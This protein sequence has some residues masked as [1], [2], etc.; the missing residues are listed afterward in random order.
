MLIIWNTHTYTDHNGTHT[1]SVM[2]AHYNTYLLSAHFT[3]D[4]KPHKNPLK[5]NTHTFFK[6]NQW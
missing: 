4:S 6:K 1:L 5:T 2:D 3:L